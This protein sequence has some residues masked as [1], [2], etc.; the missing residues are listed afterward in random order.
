MTK[1]L[2]KLEAKES[3]TPNAKCLIGLEDKG[4]LKKTYVIY[5][6]KGGR[7]KQHMENSLSINKTPLHPSSIILHPSSI[8]L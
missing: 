5:P 1:C 3:K 2:V 4:S 7:V 8:I 6:R